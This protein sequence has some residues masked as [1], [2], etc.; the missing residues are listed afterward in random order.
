MLAAVVVFPTP[1]LP[2][3]M[4]TTR[5]PPATLR[6]LTPAGCN[7]QGLRGALCS[8]AWRALALAPVQIIDL[9]ARTSPIVILSYTLLCMMGMKQ[10]KSRSEAQLL[11]CR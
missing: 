8:K 6:M 7:P 10:W 9:D 3:V 5:E 11:Q 1:P 4:H 2:D